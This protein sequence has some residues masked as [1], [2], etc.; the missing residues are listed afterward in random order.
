M[1]MN[2]NMRHKY[3]KNPIIFFIDKSTM[4]YNLDRLYIY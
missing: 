2:E 1:Y 4:K 3:Y